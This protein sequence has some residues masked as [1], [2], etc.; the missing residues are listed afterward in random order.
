MST[1]T[2]ST[3]TLTMS[4]VPQALVEYG[5]SNAAKYARQVLHGK[6]IYNGCCQL[7]IEFSKLTE[8][9]IKYNNERGW[10]FTNPTLPSGANQMM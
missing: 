2:M 8:L 6:N 1:P 3:L 4:P 9:N 10:D 5:S 7:Q